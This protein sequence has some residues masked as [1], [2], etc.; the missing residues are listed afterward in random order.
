MKKVQP[1]VGKAAKEA[2]PLLKKAVDASKPL[3]S[4]AQAKAG[5]ALEKVKA[6]TES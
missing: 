4:Q 1:Y 3:V 2:G 5:E 6:N